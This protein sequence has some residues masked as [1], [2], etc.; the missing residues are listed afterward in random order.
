MLTHRALVPRPHRRLEQDKLQ[1][2]GKVAKETD[3]KIVLST[4]WRR[5]PTLKAMCTNA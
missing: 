3:A 4:D 1:R 2:L 5:D